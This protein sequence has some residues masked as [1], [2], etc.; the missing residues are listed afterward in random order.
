MDTFEVAEGAVF[1]GTLD[2]GAGHDVLDLSTHTGD[3]SVVLSGTGLIDGFSGTLSGFAGSFTNLDEILGGSGVTD[4]LTGI[5]ADATW[6]LGTSYQYESTNTLDFSGFE[7]LLG[8][9]GV[10]TFLLEGTGSFAGEVNGGAGT[11]WISYADYDSSAEVNLGAGTATGLGGYASI[12]G[13]IG[14]DQSD[15]LLGTIWG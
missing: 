2:G 11:D 13:A 5:D 4:T 10:D 15:T 6:H 3:A 7:S 8:G 9:S 1:A 14:S 12:E